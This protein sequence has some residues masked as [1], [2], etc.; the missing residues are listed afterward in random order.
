MLLSAIIFLQLLLNDKEVLGER[1]ANK[2]W[3]NIV[4]WTIVIP[5]FV[6]LCFWP[7]RSP[8]QAVPKFLSEKCNDFDY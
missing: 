2:R 1:F 6:L 4:N 8:P 7:R 3:N 5:L